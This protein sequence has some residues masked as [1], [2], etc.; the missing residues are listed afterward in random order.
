MTADSE[1][2]LTREFLTRLLFETD[3]EIVLRSKYD[4]AE[5]LLHIGLILL[6]NQFTTLTSVLASTP[7]FGTKHITA[8]FPADKKAAIDAIVFESLRPEVQAAFRESGKNLLSALQDA[9]FRILLM[10]LVASY[11]EVKQLKERSS[12]AG[13][14]EKA[15]GDPQ[16]Q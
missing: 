7:Y 8:A 15:G 6:R 16:R 3:K 10:A 5:E 13:V 1:Q 4:S 14:P 9:P 2:D 12:D 11:E